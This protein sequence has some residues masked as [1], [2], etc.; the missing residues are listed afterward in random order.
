MV[1]GISGTGAGSGAAV[2]DD[3][4]KE[5][6]LTLLHAPS[7]IASVERTPSLA[8]IRL[9]HEQSMFSPKHFRGRTRLAAGGSEHRPTKRK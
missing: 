5:G 3:D 4:E 1:A 8:A 7:K 6:R 9:P 2:G